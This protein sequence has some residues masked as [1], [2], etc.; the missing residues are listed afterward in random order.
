MVNHSDLLDDKQLLDQLKA[1]KF[2]VAITEL[3][4]F[5]GMGSCSVTDDS[6]DIW[7]RAM[8][9][10]FT[11]ASWYFQTGIAGAVD[12][13]MKEKLG[14]KATPIW[15]AYLIKLIY[16]LGDVDDGLRT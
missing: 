15:L 6:T 9:L 8:N 7:T 2:D 1:E 4:D 16:R 5:M 11:S 14:S 3:F 10:V 12:R 13:L